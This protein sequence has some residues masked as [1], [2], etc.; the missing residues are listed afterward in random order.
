MPQNAS[1]GHLV[2]FAGTGS[3]VVFLRPN[4]LERGDEI[5]P[6]DS[7]GK[8]YVYRVEGGMGVAPET[9]RF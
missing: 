7:T 6:K 8:E 3:F 5:L 2:G 9:S 4:E 1:A